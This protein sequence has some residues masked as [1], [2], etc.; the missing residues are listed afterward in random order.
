MWPG[1]FSPESSSLSSVPTDITRYHDRLASA[2]ECINKYQADDPI[3]LTKPILQAFRDSLPQ[4]IRLKLFD[5]IVEISVS[6]LKALASH[7]YGLI[8][9]PSESHVQT[10]VWSTQIIDTVGI[11][12]GT[13]SDSQSKSFSLLR[14]NIKH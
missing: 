14:S 10:I 7:L 3:D 6:E 12:E 13:R 4:E 9:A 5:D 8:L 2:M 11:S 1:S